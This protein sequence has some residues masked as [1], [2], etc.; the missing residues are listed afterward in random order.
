[1]TLYAPTHPGRTLLPD[2]SFGRRHILT[3]IAAVIA[4]ALVSVALLTSGLPA[5]FD[6][7]AG[8]PA[9]GASGPEGLPGAARQ[10]ASATPTATLT[11]T[12]SPS[13]T[14]LPTVVGPQADPL[15]LT[16]TAFV[17]QATALAPF[18]SPM[19]VTATPILFPPSASTGS[20]EAGGVEVVPLMPTV[21]PPSVEFS[22]SGGVTSGGW[23]PMLM[24]L[25]VGSTASFGLTAGS[26]T[27][28]QITAEEEGA[29]VITTTSLD[30]TPRLV[31]VAL[32]DPDLGI[33]RSQDGQSP[34]EVTVPVSPGDRVLIFVYS[35]D[36]EATG[37]FLINAHMG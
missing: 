26:V 7:A 13:P 3:L 10:A 20:I 5:S 1:M 29:L 19:V 22:A 8:G 33:Y 4:V 12:P 2:R 11:P 14:W 34:P 9:D 16:A 27:S 15:I 17:E 18:A 24:T 25:P 30:F 32:D 28:F 6:G 35:A 36:R 21:Y 23:Q 37:Q 31:V